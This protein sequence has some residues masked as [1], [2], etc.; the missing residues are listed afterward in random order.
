MAVAVIERVP[1]RWSDRAKIDE[2]RRE[3]P[4][5][6]SL[7]CHSSRLINTVVD[8]AAPLLRQ[9]T[10]EIQFRAVTFVSEIVMVIK[11]DRHTSSRL[12]VLLQCKQYYGCEL[13]KQSSI[14]FLPEVTIEEPH[15]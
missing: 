10:V 9:R 7:N 1:G 13:H 14:T 4:S 12:L 5:G 11:Y 3:R 2:K 8:S 6:R 15:L